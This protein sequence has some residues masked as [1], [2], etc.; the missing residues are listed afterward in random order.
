MGIGVQFGDVEF[1]DAR[2]HRSKEHG[3]MSRYYWSRFCWFQS[4]YCIHAAIT[5]PR[6]GI[7]T[8]PYLGT[9]LLRHGDKPVPSIDCAETL[10]EQLFAKPH[11]QIA[12]GNSGFG[13]ARCSGQYMTR[14]KVS[15]GEFGSI[16]VLIRTHLCFGNHCRLCQ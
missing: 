8:I 1:S 10:L 15:R 5:V 12:I 14:V 7:D 13:I 11:N 2:C 4:L 3:C 9:T 6:Y 16:K